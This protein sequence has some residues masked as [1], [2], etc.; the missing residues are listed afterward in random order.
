MSLPLIK[1]R[2][3]V[4]LCIL[5]GWGVNKEN[6]KHIVDAIKRA[7]TPFYDK[8]LQKYPNS[9]I[10]ASSTEVGLPDG[11]IGNSEVGHCAIGSGRVVYQDLPRINKYINGGLL[12]KNQKIKNL[13]AK[14]KEKNSTCH[15]I[16]M[17]SDGGVH[18]HNNHIFEITKLITSVGVEVCLH[19]FTDGRDVGQ[20]TVKKYIKDFHQEFASN[21]KVKIATI[22]GRYYGMDR[23]KN[24]DRT[25]IA[26]DAIVNGQGDKFD[27]ISKLIDENYQNN[28]TD[29][30]FTPAVEKQ[31]KGV[32]DN[33][34][35]F[36]LNFR[37]DRVRQIAEAIVNHNFK[38]FVIKKVNFSAK[39]S[40]TEYSDFLN[41]F[42]DVIFPKIEIKNSLGEI[43]QDKALKQL[44]IAE[45]EKYAH[46]TFFFSG[47]KEKPFNNE[48]R[49]LI[50]S[51]K[52]DYYD[53][54]PEMSGREVTEEI[55]TKIDNGNFDFILVNYA[56][57]DMIGHSGNLE[58]A[59]KACEFIDRQL[60][61]LY[62]KV[63]LENDY[64]MIITADHGN[65]EDMVDNKGNPH[66]SH[67]LNPVPFIILSNNLKNI[68]LK[69]GSLQD[70]APTILDIM[71][72]NKPKEMTGCSLVK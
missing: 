19:I 38:H 52:I 58:S 50:N 59:I 31:Y 39:L 30:F 16:G 44:R 56:N 13:I 6:K 27:N 9:L 68:S 46:V 71:E 8:I 22:V 12:A 40:I 60:E 67:T 26:Y 36:F 72:I 28:I 65:I 35:I 17:F 43:L 57:P 61:D 62:N 55:I 37:I 45:T 1:K 69:D 2:S 47:G 3:K 64:V 4:L 70:I 32:K 34:A 42:F 53:K 29:E 5:D 10:S 20:K 41:R 51:P 23:D 15:L 7:D 21:N 66:T 54:L 48:E 63:V 25:K 33:D 18:S 11:Q 24:W 49:V 14:S